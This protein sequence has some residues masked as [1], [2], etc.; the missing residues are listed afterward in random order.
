MQY[1]IVEARL[2]IKAGIAFA[3]SFGD[4][5]RLVLGACPKHTRSKLFHVKCRKIPK[6]SSTSLMPTPSAKSVFEESTFGQTSPR[7]FAKCPIL[8]SR[9]WHFCRK[10]AGIDAEIDE[11]VNE[12][13]ASERRDY[14]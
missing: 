5:A 10:A 8:F 13:S 4:V 14:A 12:D 3:R 6:Q 2:K 1:R 9:T 7:L 11:R